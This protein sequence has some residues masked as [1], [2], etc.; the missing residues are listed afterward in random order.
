ME[1]KS[2]WKRWG[3]GEV[4]SMGKATSLGKVV[5]MGK[6]SVGKGSVSK[7]TSGLGAVVSRPQ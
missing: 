6:H 5:S 4:G 1:S 3:N 7:C 2:Q